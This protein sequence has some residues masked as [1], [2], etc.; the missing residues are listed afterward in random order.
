MK[1]PGYNYLTQRNPQNTYRLKQNFFRSPRGTGENNGGGKR[2]MLKKKKITLSRIRKLL[3][4]RG[5]F[6]YN[7]WG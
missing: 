6:D 4:D 5:F 1:I 3:T 7:W 2:E